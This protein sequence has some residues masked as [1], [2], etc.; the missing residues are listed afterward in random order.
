MDKTQWPGLQRFRT[1]TRNVRTLY[2]KKAFGT[3]VDATDRY[4]I[5][6]V[7]LQEKGKG[8]ISTGNITLFCNMHTHG[9][10]QQFYNVV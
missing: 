1:D 7:A 5:N 4:K 8:C 10:T 3:L 6:I 2:K 9:G